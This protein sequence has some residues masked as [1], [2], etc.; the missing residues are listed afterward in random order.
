MSRNV[1]LLP[2]STALFFFLAAVM[3]AAAE[4]SAN[5]SAWTVISAAELARE[6]GGESPT[7]PTSYI[8]EEAE[9]R[10]NTVTNS[11]SGDNRVSSGAF[12][13]A[14]GFSTVIQ[15]SGNHVVIQDSTVVNLTIQK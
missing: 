6:R 2:L 12:S 4:E 10:D 9:I 3:P 15:N 11:N 5:F 1:S 13:G 8:F 14:S 7:T